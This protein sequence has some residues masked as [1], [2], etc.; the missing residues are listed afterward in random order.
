VRACGRVRAR[1]CAYS[2]RARKHQCPAR[3]YL[4]QPLEAVERREARRSRQPRPQQPVPGVP[5]ATS[6]A[7]GGGKGQVDP[8]KEKGQVDPVERRA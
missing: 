8:K 7:A 6:T 3:S 2:L 1:V 5:Y 4:G